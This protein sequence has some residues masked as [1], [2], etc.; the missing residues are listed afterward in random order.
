MKHILSPDSFFLLSGL[1]R[2]FW[3]CS[4]FVLIYGGSAF[5]RILSFGNYGMCEPRHDKSNKMRLRPAKTQISLDIRPVWS[6]SSLSAWRNIG[7]LATHWAHSEDSDQSGRM[8]DVLDVQSLCWFWQVAAR[9][10]FGVFS[11]MITALGEAGAGRFTI[12]TAKYMSNGIQPC[13]ILHQITDSMGATRAVECHLEF[14]MK[15]VCC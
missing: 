7:S 13:L 12:R 5:S 6:E 8:L 9:D 10:S 1:K 15:S 14:S 3:C 2:R 11:I 4:I